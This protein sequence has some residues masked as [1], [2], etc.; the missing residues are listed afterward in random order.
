MDYIGSKSKLNAWIFSKIEKFYPNPS[1]VSLLD[2]CSGSGSVSR[3]AAGLGYSV[4]ACDALMFSTHLVSGSIGVESLLEDAARHVEIINGLSGVDGFFYQN[5]SQHSGRLYF[6]DENASKI[7]AARQYVE[8]INDPKLKSML[9]YFLIEALSRVGNTSGTHGAY[10][11]RLKERA[12]EP[13]KVRIE[14]T[15]PGSA[16]AYCDDVIN[17]LNNT[18]VPASNVLYID[19]PYNQ[20][21][22]A[23]NYHLYETLARYDNPEIKGKTGLRADWAH[24]AKSGFCNK[25]SFLILLDTIIRTTKSPLILLSY[26]SDGI[27]KSDEIFNCVLENDLVDNN[28]VCLYVRDQRRY[29]ADGQRQYNEDFLKEFLFVFLKKG[30]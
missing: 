19:P 5:Y 14:K 22:Y 7:D 12:L 13:F 15:V 26:S 24:E 1:E 11:K 21:Q 10:L 25:K 28:N 4:V 18:E 16:V 8:T 29:K 9:I 20:R 3:Y 6:T 23:P 30:T 27:V 17:L 2:A